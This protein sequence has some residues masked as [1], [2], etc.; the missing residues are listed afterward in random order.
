MIP[1]AFVRL[2]ALPLTSNGKLDGRALPEPERDAFVRNDYGEPQG[3]IENALASIW[4]DLLKVERIGRH[5]NF[6]MIG[7]HSLLAVRLI[8][9]VRS[10]L[11]FEMKLRSL[12][13][14]PTIAQLSAK[15]F[16]VEDMQEDLLDV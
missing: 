1:A 3:E 11:G 5:D 6:F 14:A 13:E 12:F 10:S 8:G 16:E 15:L 7:G 4:V 9:V 2:D